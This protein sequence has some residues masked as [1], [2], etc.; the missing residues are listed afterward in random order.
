M[1]SNKQAKVALEWSRLLG[2]DQMTVRD[3]GEPIR[4]LKDSRLAKVGGKSC[5]TIPGVRP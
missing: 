2:F 1:T 3:D 4:Q 5:S